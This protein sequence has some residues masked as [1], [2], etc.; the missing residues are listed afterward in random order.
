MNCD[1][2]PQEWGE[3][4]VKRLEER[5]GLSDEEARKKVEEWFASAVAVNQNDRLLTRGS[6]T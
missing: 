2:I 4:L 3:D 6:A 5:F 1:Q